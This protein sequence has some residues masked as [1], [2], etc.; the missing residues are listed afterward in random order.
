M[1]RTDWRKSAGLFLLVFACYAV[2]AVLPLKAFGASELGP[3]FF[4]AAGVTVSALLLNPRT[5]WPAVIAAVVAA[6]TMVDV[7]EGYSPWAIAGYALANSV[8]PLVGATL[9]LRWCGGRPDLRRRRDLLAF[10][11]GACLAGPLAGGAIG[12]G[13][14]AAHFGVW[15][16]GAAL[17]WFA[18]DAI[19]VLVVAAPILLWPRQVHDLRSRPVE[20]VGIVGCT[21][22]LSWLAM[23]TGLS[24]A[25]LILPVLAW[26][27]LRLNVLG[28]ALAGA[29][30]AFAANLRSAA[31]LGMFNDLDLSAPAKLALIQ[32]LIGVNVLLAML[33]AQ[34]AA[35]RRR[36]A[37]Q[38]AIERQERR[39][40]LGL[41]RL[42]RQL[43]AALT[44]DDIG[45]VLQTRLLADV[46]AVGVNL[47]QLSADGTQLDWVLTAGYPAAVAD[48]FGAGVPMSRRCVGTDA[49]R[50]GQPVLLSSPEAYQ[51]AY[52]AHTEWLRAAGAASIGGWPLASGDR[53]VGVL[54][55]VWPQP[56]ELHEAQQAYFAAVAAMVGE[57]WR[58]AK[59]Y[60]DE[61]ARASALHSAAHPAGPTD[62]VGLDYRAVYRPAEAAEGLGGDWYSVLGLD[63]GRTYLAVGDVVGHGLAAVEDM[64]QMRSAGNAYAHQGLGPARLLTDLS[65][66]ARRVCAAEFATTAV[67]VYDPATAMLA[68]GSAGHPPALL[69]RAATGEVIRLDDANGP[70]LG[71]PDDTGYPQGVIAIEAG[72]VL[73]MYTDGLVE[74]HGQNVH[75]GI[76]HLE[77][78]ITAWPPAALLDCEALADDIAPSPHTDD[79]CLVVVRFGESRRN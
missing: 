36:V 4:P 60:S 25:I 33:I 78:V 59:S 53:T 5:R 68:Y 34:E 11:A 14:V 57:A 46:G 39:R 61:H 45:R 55:L 62:T 70:V 7:A 21:A 29:M 24:P 3:A 76:D 6:E 19:G 67:A 26:A 23:W 18:A 2:G 79:V 73:A 28:A 71:L 38:R 42:A 35:G 20:T 9:V 47:G 17:R 40:L 43:S 75:A 12:G 32:A 48:E 64:A 51:Q 16:P 66:Y 56:H 41:A 15:W 13:A 27:G 58:R 1:K 10:V 50:T 8:E 31:G 54:V 77:Q 63:D 44:P 65:R 37:R 49:V 72:D 74:H 30:A 52:G 69:R 22:A